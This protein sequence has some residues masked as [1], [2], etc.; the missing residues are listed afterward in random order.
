VPPLTWC[1][2]YSV[3]VESIDSQHRV[4]I[5]LIN[6]LREAIESNATT[7]DIGFVVDEFLFY[8]AGHLDYE[9]RLLESSG[10]AQTQEHKLEHDEL[11]QKAL[12]IEK[13]FSSGD[14]GTLPQE[15][16]AFLND[17]FRRHV[18][19]SDMMFGP[20]LVAHQIV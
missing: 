16:C 5:R 7:H 1:E 17:W 4:L 6:Q 19:G 3:G 14:V 18:L 2:H 10:Y 20:H 13:R 9:E 8:T 11:R 12:A 15:L